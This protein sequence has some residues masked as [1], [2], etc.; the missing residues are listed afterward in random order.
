MN[1]I[2]KKLIYLRKQ[3]YKKEGSYEDSYIY[4]MNGIDRII[5]ELEDEKHN[6]NKR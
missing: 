6:T 5:G 2:L 4:L 1:K 3:A